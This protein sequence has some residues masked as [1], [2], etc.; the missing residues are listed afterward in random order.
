MYIV[1]YHLL[2]FE[3][4][5]EGTKSSI[6][7]LH[8]SKTPAT[9]L[10]SKFEGT[11]ILSTYQ[12]TVVGLSFFRVRSKAR[13]FPI[14]SIW[15]KTA[16]Q[17]NKILSWG[18][19][20][21]LHDARGTHAKSHGMEVPSVKERGDRRFVA[22]VQ[23]FLESQA[24]HLYYSFYCYTS[25]SDDWKLRYLCQITVNKIVLPQVLRHSW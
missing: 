14:W 12:L 6:V 10:M 2:L 8:L 24:R 16:L 25:R 15:D 13:K 1:V 22:F 7:G 18:L 21:G 9:T 11:G 19:A 5:H 17:W 4:L 3:L 23:T 20:I